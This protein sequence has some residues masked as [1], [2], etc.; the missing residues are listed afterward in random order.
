MS[1]NLLSPK[2]ALIRPIR[3][4]AYSTTS[5]TFEHSPLTPFKTAP[6]VAQ[7]LALPIRPPEKI[8]PVIL[9]MNLLGGDHAP[10]DNPVLNYERR[11]KQWLKLQP[12]A[13]IVPIIYQKHDG[14]ISEKI[15][16]ALLPDEE[17]THLMNRT[18]G[19]SSK[20]LT[21][22][23]ASED[24]VLDHEETVTPPQAHPLIDLS[25]GRDR[26]IVFI[27]EKARAFLPAEYSVDP[28]NT[29]FA[30]D[31]FREIQG[32]FAQN[33]RIMISAC[34]IVAG[35]ESE[36]EQNFKLLQRSFHLKDSLIYANR[37]DGMEYSSLYSQ[38]FF[39]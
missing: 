7:E 35:D 2:A 25:L 22:A 15:S 23:P 11:Q 12:S 34:R 20:V 36:A 37:T 4:L 17:I 9:Y 30:E 28:E 26:S 5:H 27:D 31:V 8:R 21:P 10:S 33:S 38:A 1:F 24:Q 14:H 32:R 3:H 29:L 16:E 39:K 6:Q 19:T 13:R 18:H